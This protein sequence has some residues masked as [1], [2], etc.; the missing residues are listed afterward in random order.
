MVEDTQEGGGKDN[1]GEDH[2]KKH[3]PHFVTIGQRAED[4]GGTL[5]GVGQNSRKEFFGPFKK[6]LA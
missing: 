6:C 2:G 5:I 3:K 1:C 4:E